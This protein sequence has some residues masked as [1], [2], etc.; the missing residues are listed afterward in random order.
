[1]SADNQLELRWVHKT[2]GQDRVAARF[3]NDT[4]KV[5]ETENGTFWEWE[6]KLRGPSADGRDNAKYRQHFAS[7][8]VDTPDGSL[9]PSDPK[10]FLELM[11]MAGIYSAVIYGFTRKPNFEDAELWRECYRAYNDFLLDFDSHAPERIIAPPQM[12][13]VFP[14]TCLAEFLRVVARGS[15]AVECVVFGAAKPPG[16]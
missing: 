7:M 1:R 15:K 14:E 11:D 2:A 10:V 8:G 3:Q 6:G 4:P 5:V 16:Q 9:P 13:V 12:P